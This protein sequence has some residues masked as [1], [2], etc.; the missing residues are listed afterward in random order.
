MQT[1]RPQV[2]DF[3]HP[4]HMA[5]ADIWQEVLGSFS[6]QSAFCMEWL[7]DHLEQ[8]RLPK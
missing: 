5:H 7:L 3:A 6:L 2:A 4:P 8:T 1:L